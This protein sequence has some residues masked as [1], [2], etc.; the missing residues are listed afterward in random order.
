MIYIYN[1][2]ILSLFSQRIK[3]IIQTET[4][5]DHGL[6]ARCQRLGI[7]GIFQLLEVRCQRQLSEALRH[8]VPLRHQQR[9]VDV[10]LQSVA[11]QS[12]ESNVVNMIIYVNILILSCDI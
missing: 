4:A 11:G 8:M 9:R 6:Q 2:Y 10:H 7:V 1:I 3:K 12:P 5:N